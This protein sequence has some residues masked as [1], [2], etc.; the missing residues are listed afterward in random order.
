MATIEYEGK[1]FTVDEDGFLENLDPQLAG[2]HARY[3][4]PARRP[5]PVRDAWWR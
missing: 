4:D 5:E 3:V 1:T 2:A